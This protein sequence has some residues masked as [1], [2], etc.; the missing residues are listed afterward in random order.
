MVQL[1]GMEYLYPYES[2]N[3]ALSNG[4]SDAIIRPNPAE[5]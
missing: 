2:L 3:L 1:A 5:L 4:A